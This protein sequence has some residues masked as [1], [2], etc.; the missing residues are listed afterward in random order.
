MENS[1]KHIGRPRKYNDYQIIGNCAYVT[2]GLTN[3]VM[4][5][6]ADDWLN[7]KDY[8]WFEQ[9]D[10]GY[11]Q[12]T[13]NGKHVSY[14]SHLLKE[15]DGYVRDHINRNKLDNRQKNLRY[16]SYQANSI[17]TKISKANTSGAK[18]VIYDKTRQKWRAEI[19]IRGKKKNLGRFD[20]YEDAI[21]ARKQA[22]EKYYNPIFEKETFHSESFF[23]TH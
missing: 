17:N 20:N 13:I 14:H 7:W 6:D 5:C 23:N 21:K 12:A 16:A 9:K 2:L 8:Y 10:R 4:I 15:I 11:V 18:G 22:E 1:N 3:N 19:T